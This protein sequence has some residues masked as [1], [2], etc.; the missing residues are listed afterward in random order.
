MFVLSSYKAK[1]RGIAVAVKELKY[2]NLTPEVLEEFRKE[3]SILAYVF[4]PPILVRNSLTF[5]RL[6]NFATPTSF[7]LWELLHNPHISPWLLNTLA[8]E[9][10]TKYY[11]KSEYS[12]SQIPS[13]FHLPS[14]KNSL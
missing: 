9:I 7:C 13:T 10:S 8:E 11:T 5:H 12:F 1:W 6:A 3:I 2:T 14:P 4:F